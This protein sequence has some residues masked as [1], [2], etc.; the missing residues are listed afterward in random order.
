MWEKLRILNYELK[1][2]KLCLLRSYRELEGDRRRYKTF[3]F[4]CIV[5]YLRR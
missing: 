3:A 5:L 4:C 2:R 1:F